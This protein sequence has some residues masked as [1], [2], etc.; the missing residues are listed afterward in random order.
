MEIRVRIKSFLGTRSEGFQISFII[1]FEACLTKNSQP[2]HQGWQFYLHHFSLTIIL[3]P[4]AHCSP[5]G[6]ACIDKLCRRSWSATIEPNCL[7]GPVS[8]LCTSPYSTVRS[9]ASVS[10]CTF[11][12]ETR[13]SL[14]SQLVLRHWPGEPS[15]RLTGISDG[16][17][18]S[19][20]QA[21]GSV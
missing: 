15:L 8:P 6:R 20:V 9:A 19:P 7:W 12:S 1:G 10:S 16:W 11:G 17:I 13:F 5:T 21:L 14:E 2:K 18:S 3:G 4:S